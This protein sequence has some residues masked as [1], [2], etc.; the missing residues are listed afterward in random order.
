MDS[1]I[2]KIFKSSIWSSL[3]LLVLGILLIFQSEIT[4]ISIA[5]VIGAL[6]IAIGVIG[7]VKYL[8][9]INNK[10]RNELDIIYGIVTIILGI[11]IIT[12]PQAIAGIIPFIIG[13]IIIVASSLKLQYSMDLKKNKNDLWKSTMILSIIS[14]LCGILLIFNPFKG[15]VFITK[16][17]GS[18]III[19]SIL[20]IVSSLS[21]RK[22]SKTFNKEIEKYVT[23]ANVV[24]EETEHKKTK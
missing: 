19:Y 7:L 5:Y 2:I 22:T 17:I 4:I 9:S 20:D 15:A 24:N 13:I 18:L 12:N 14:I 21:I 3:G 23:E 8:K 1:I 6:L 16:V 11:M 10:E